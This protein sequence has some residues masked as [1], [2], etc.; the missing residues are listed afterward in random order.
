MRV[1]LVLIG[2]L[3]WAGVALLAVAMAAWDEPVIGFFPILI[4]VFAAWAIGEYLTNAYLT[5]DGNHD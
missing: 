4:A 3:V 1:A 5:R 2:V